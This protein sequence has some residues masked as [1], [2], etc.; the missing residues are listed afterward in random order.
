MAAFPANGSDINDSSDTTSIQSKW[1][2]TRIPQGGCVSLEF[3][4]AILPNSWLACA[5]ACGRNLKNCTASIRKPTSATYSPSSSL[6]GSPRASTDS[7]PG[8]AAVHHTPA[9]L[10]QRVAKRPEKSSPQSRGPDGAYAYGTV[11]PARARPNYSVVHAIV[12]AP[13]EPNTGESAF[14]HSD[15]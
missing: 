6:S 4:A 12:K 2:T 9:A 13:P 1:R 10:M 5:D 8:P 3:E 7:C 11:T 15:G 14:R